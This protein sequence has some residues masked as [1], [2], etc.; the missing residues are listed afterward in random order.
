MR[1]ILFAGTNFYPDGGWC[2]YAGAF[3]SVE[4][5]KQALDTSYN[6]WAHVVDLTTGEMVVTFLSHTKRW[7]DEHET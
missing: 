1:F 4:A 3:E 5:A 7:S 2:D 6:D